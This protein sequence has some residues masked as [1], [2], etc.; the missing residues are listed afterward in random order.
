MQRAMDETERRRTKQMAWNEEHGI[1]P[2]TIRRDVADILGELGE[3]KDTG[4]RGKGRGRGK[5]GGKSR[6]RAVAEEKALPLSGESGHNL[7]AV[8]ADLEKQ[9]REAA[10]NLEFEDAAR[11]RDEV[12][13]L[14]E[15]ELGL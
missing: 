13:R 11:L 5:D 12:K 3:K 7:K 4:S 8:I 9:M 6:A 2:T 15:E 14:R 1:T 10:A